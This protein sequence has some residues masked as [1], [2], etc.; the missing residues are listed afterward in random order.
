MASSSSTTV[1]VKKHD[2]FLSFC[3]VDTR[4]TFTSTLLGILQSSGIDVFIDN[5]LKRGEHIS[6]SLIKEISDSMISVIIFSERYAS[7][8]WCLEELVKI[9]ECRNTEKQVV[10]PVF[11]HTPSDVRHQT[12]YFG[13]GFKKLL[14]SLDK[15]KLE[16]VQRTKKVLQWKNALREAANISGRSTEEDPFDY[17]L[18]NKVFQDIWLTLNNMIPTNNYGDLVGVAS[19]IPHL[20]DLLSTR[21]GNIHVIGIWGMP[22][23]GKTTITNCVFNQ[24]RSH[25]EGSYFA[26]NIREKSMSPNQLKPIR[27][28]LLS[29]IF[30][31]ADLVINSKVTETMLRRKRVLIVLDDVTTLSQIEYLVG[32][33]Y[34]L[35]RGSRI[36]ITTTDRQVLRNCGVYER[37]IYEMRG[38]PEDEALKLFSWYAFKQSNPNKDYDDLSK[39]VVKYVEGIPLALKVLG[40]YLLG[41][42]KQIW[43]SAINRLEIIPHK[44]IHNVLKVCYEGLSDDEHNMFL[45]IACFLKLENIEF[46]MDFLNACYLEAEIEVSVLKDNCL[47]N[48]SRDNKVIMH[49]LLQ[50][51]GREIVRQEFPRNPGTRS[52]LWYH[53]DIDS[54]LK[55]N[56]MSNAIEGICLDMSQQVEDIYLQPS[57]LGVMDQL[58]FFKLHNSVDNIN[59]VYV[60]HRLSSMSSELRYV[61]WYGCPLESLQPNFLSK[62]LVALDMPHSHIDQLR[63]SVQLVNLK[64]IDLSFSKRLRS[65]DLSLTPNV[66]ILVLE[67]CTSL[68]EISS[69]IHG[70]KYELHM[71]NLR[72]CRSLESLPTDIH[73]A[74][75]EK[76]IFSGCSKLKQFPQASWDMKEIYLDETAIE[77]LPSSIENLSRLVI[78]NLKDCSMLQRLPSNIRQLKS[79][80]Y[81]N[82]SGCLKLDGLP[83]KLGNLEALRVLKA[84]RVA[85]REVPTSILNLRCLEELD[86]TNCSIVKLPNNLGQ[87][88]S[89][90]SL[91]LGRNFFNSIPESIEQLSELS[92]LDVSYCERLQILPKLPRKLDNINANNCISLE[93][94]L[95]LR[96]LLERDFSH[97]IRFNFSNCFKLNQNSC[98]KIV[99]QFRQSVHQI[100]RRLGP[101]IFLKTDRSYFCFPGSEIPGW[102]T[103]NGIGSFLTLAPWAFFRSSELTSLLIYVV[104]EFRDYHNKDQGLAIGF[105]WLLTTEDGVEEVI[106]GTWSIWD[107]GTGP[108]YVDSD[109]VF[110]GIDHTFKFDDPLLPRDKRYFGISIR[111]HVENSYTERLDYC[112][113]KKCGFF[114]PDKNP[115]QVSNAIEGICLDM[116]QQAENIDLQPSSLGVMDQLRFFKLYNSVD[117]INKVH[118]SDKL[119]FISSELRYVCWY[120]CPLESL[121]PNFLSK[122]LVALD[123]PHSHIDQLR[124]SVQLV[125]LKRIDLS[126]SKRLRSQD[127][128]LTPNVK[129]LVLEGCKRLHEISS[130]IHGCKYELHMLNLRHCRS[131]ESLPT[132]IHVASFEKVIFSGCSKLKQFP[133]ALWDKKEIYLDETAIEDLPSSIENLSRLVILNLKDCSMLQRLPSSI[134]QL[135][136]LQYLNL[137]GCLK[138]DGLPDK[139]GNL[140]AL[141]VL[142]AERVA[143]REVPTSILNLRCLEELDLTNSSIVKL[144][145]N[146][147]QL[148]SLKSLLLGRNFFDSIPESIEQLSELSYLDV[149]YCE[150]LQILPKL[151]SKLDNI[152]ANNCIS[153]EEPLSLR[154]L[155][156]RDFSPGIRFNFSN[157]F[158][159]N[160]NSCSK[161]MRQFQMSANLQILRGLGQE[162]FLGTD[163]SY[164]CFPG[165]EIPEWFTLRATGSSVWYPWPNFW[166]SDLTSLLVCAVVEFRDYNKDRGLAIG[167]DWL[168]QRE[169]GAEVVIHGTWSVWDNGTGPDYLESD[170]VFLGFYPTFKFD[171]PLL[172]RDERYDG[173]GIR[174]HVQNSYAERLHDCNVKKCGFFG[175]YLNP[176]EVN[177]LPFLFPFYCVIYLFKI[178]FYFDS[179]V[180][181]PHVYLSLLHL[182]ITNAICHWFSFVILHLRSR[183]NVP[184]TNSLLIHITLIQCKLESSPILISLT[185]DGKKFCDQYLFVINFLTTEMKPLC[186]LPLL[187]RF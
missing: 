1:E 39:R 113:V 61:C 140:E 12:G 34:S 10:I 71:L 170:H 40:C 118:V 78:L 41:K 184:Q 9:L 3:G 84:E 111:F 21:L 56:K 64:R 160:Q 107:D 57:S 13:E 43:E 171:D 178:L 19:T 142:K 175:Q 48:I 4:L 148:S 82:L 163:R 132:D 8:R 128:S 45:D 23:I 135:K 89:L 126:F 177:K 62:N 81:L 93:E 91:L 59:K 125:N 147:G 60:S 95:S 32:D 158:K 181:V 151:P 2:V 52:R 169:H 94:P 116:S 185:L 110:L 42:S 55:E 28:E 14:G 162:I 159:L 101:E 100:L 20:I 123:M 44:D 124:S 131:L 53:R 109:H 130:S 46:V 157:C 133:Q 134:Y 67:G 114:V 24:I 117:N 136:S 137:S 79:L 17:S 6:S 72:H 182:T 47:M 26:D 38:L 174:F 172:P 146:L 154:D 77:D 22:G 25:F 167:L 155:L 150:R 153:L 31:R 102:F 66:K 69:S 180:Y 104:V 144:P 165:S 120:G 37:Y 51:M 76:V 80:Q 145:N 138:L 50:A 92:Y 27:Q 152:N 49:N 176:V 166:S 156:K 90:K 108:D 139:L 65:Q 106:H 129:I 168:L 112:K 121:Q 75:F 15:G 164:F 187:P 119:S 87:L 122:N 149:S 98:S 143:T 30:K 7:S 35:G 33:I 36:I 141:R 68:H 85:T 86:I 11:Y 29:T 5:E 63:S 103:F 74:S 54:V 179:R 16:R 173:I 161:I 70:C 186:T 99:R 58:R 183:P 96:D 97:S 127:L 18:A 115:P 105:E 88:S 73:V 83:D